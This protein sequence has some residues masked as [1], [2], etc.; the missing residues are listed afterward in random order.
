[1]TLMWLTRDSYFIKK[2]LFPITRINVFY[3]VRE[4]QV[5]CFQSTPVSQNSG[6]RNSTMGKISLK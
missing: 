2:H 1:M 6:K 3:S 5:S 4:S